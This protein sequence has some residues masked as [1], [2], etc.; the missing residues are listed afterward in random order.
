MLLRVL[1]AAA[2]GCMRTACGRLPSQTRAKRAALVGPPTLKAF[3]H[4]VFA[5]RCEK[6]SGSKLKKSS[7]AGAKFMRQLCMVFVGRMHA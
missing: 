4:K 3:A 6:K 2:Q 1:P 7:N 5:G